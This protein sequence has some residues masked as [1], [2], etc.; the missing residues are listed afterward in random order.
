MGDSSKR[1]K[2]RY[3]KGIRNKV[4]DIE[5]DQKGDHRCPNCGSEKL[6]RASS[7]VWK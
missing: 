4:S 2:S 5:E 7:G 1:F 3:G 6:K